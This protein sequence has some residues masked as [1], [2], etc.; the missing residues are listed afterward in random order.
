MI[1]KKYYYNVKNRSA[2]VILYTIPE[3]KVRRRFTPGETKRI[4]YEELL[5]LSYQPGGREMM[6]NFLQ[7]QSEGVPKS[8]GINT[9]PEYYM[10]ENDVI[11]LLKNG[12]L[13]AF[14]DCLDF[15]PTGVQELIKKFAVELPLTDF[16]KR[17]AL[18]AKTGFDVDKAIANAGQEQDEATEK[19]V[20]QKVATPTTGRRT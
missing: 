20:E 17:A 10:S 15:A 1:D 11:E 14:L 19:A 12:T 2:G 9:E 16:E 7:I 13:D 6:Q 4:S 3:D 5:H 8:L 18:K